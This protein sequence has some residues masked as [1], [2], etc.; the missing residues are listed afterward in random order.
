MTLFS[1]NFTGGI[2]QK[3]IEVVYYAL[4]RGALSDDAVWRLSDVCCVHPVGGRRVRPA[5]WIIARIG[6]SGPARLGRPGS[7]LPLCASVAGLGHIVA[8]ARLNSVSEV[9]WRLQPTAT[10]RS[11]RFNK[12]RRLCAHCTCLSMRTLRKWLKRNSGQWSPN[13]SP[14]LNTMEVPC[15]RS[16]TKLFWNLFIYNFISPT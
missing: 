14:N 16:D 12:M 7:R 3:V 5:D 4:P 11:S 15:L 10:R 9:H 2:V 13:D 6:R 8:A 1:R